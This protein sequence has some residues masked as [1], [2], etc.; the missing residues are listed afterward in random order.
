MSAPYDF[1]KIIPSVYGDRRPVTGEAVALLHIS[2]D[3]R[4]WSL[5]LLRAVP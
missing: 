5:S 4:D 3:D 2:F 1:N